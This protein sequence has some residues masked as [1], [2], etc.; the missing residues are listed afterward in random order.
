M[1]F[2]EWF[3]ELSFVESWEFLNN[4][5]IWPSFRIKFMSLVKWQKTFNSDWSTEIRYFKSM[6]K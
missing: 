2:T 5:L 1:G 6:L 3:V 4:V